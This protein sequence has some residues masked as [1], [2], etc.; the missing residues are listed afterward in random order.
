M[1]Q[2]TTT[3]EADNVLVE[4]D[5]RYAIGIPL[6]DDQHKELIQLTNELYKSCLAGDEAARANFGTAVKGT[7]D[8]VKYHFSAEEKILENVKYPEIG[9]H[10]RQHE[11]FVK[12]VLED[13][14]N[15]QEG[16]KFVPNVFVRFLKDWIL[17]HIAVMDTQYA[18]Y[19]QNLKKQGALD[20]AIGI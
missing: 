9:E 12:Q 3:A 16:K 19:I 18:K 1:A 4:W 14:Q 20:S 10:K 13:V 17:S 15:F 2:I 8:Y 11:V 6:I 7:V 5:N